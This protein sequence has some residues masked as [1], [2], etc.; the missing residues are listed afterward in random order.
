MNN[1]IRKTLSTFWSRCIAF[2]LWTVEWLFF[3]PR[4]KTFYQRNVQ[5]RPVIFD[6][7]ANRG[8][9]IRFFQSIFVE[10]TIHAFEPSPSI[11]RL[12]SKFISVH[13][14]VHNV[15][16]SST[17]GTKLFYES[18]LDEVSTFEKPDMSSNYFKLKSKILLSS[19]K[20]MYSEVTVRVVRMDNFLN[21]HGIDHIDICK[22]DVEGHELEVL[23]GAEETLRNK[24][25]RFLQIEIHHDDQYKA[26]PE[27]V[28]S[29]LSQFGYKEE[30]S[31]KHGFG[32][33]YDVIFSTNH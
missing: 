9:S 4:L 22:I 28:T 2:A 11:F 16:L 18:I 27:L 24:R 10:P 7:G 12:L 29:Y 31:I 26:S 25:I 33:F 5:S 32:N 17:N 1:P 20:T 30:I 3:Y 14:S 23:K 19:P 15:G 6:V 13:V 21:N 8:Q